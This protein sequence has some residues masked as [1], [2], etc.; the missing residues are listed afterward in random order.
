MTKRLLLIISLLA[1]AACGQGRQPQ[2][3]SPE[4]ILSRMR[5][6]SAWTRELDSLACLALGPGARCIDPVWH[7]FS[8]EGR[9]WFHNQDWG[10]VLQLPDGFTP[11]DDRWQ[12]ELS[13]HGTAATSAD[14]L[15]RLSFYAGYSVSSEEERMEALTESLRKDGFTIGSIVRGTV[16]FGGGVVSPVLTVRARSGEGIHYYA[17]HILRGPD[18]VTFSVALQ[19]DDAVADE[20]AEYIPMV[21]RYPFSPDGRFFRG[22]A[23]K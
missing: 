17:R 5:A 22:E 21:E 10:G 18:G 4:D 3:S 11:E 2:S 8:W 9:R 1:A 15:M 23:V 19:Y 20:A 7:L 14:S 13:F 12:A 16:S 6:D